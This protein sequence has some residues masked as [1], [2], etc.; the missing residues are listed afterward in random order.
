MNPLQ[1]AL[2]LGLAAL[3]SLGCGSPRSRPPLVPDS[4]AW[5]SCPSGGSGRADLSCELA[6]LDRAGVVLLSGRATETAALT[7]LVH[8]VRIH[9]GSTIDGRRSAR[10]EVAVRSTQTT[11]TNLPSAAANDSTAALGPSSREQP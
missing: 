3:L 1:L 11:H 6:V 2:A 4:P 9:L 8:T 10:F 5:A 7:V